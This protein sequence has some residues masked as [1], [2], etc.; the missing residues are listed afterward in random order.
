MFVSF[1]T[2]SLFF[3]A[4]KIPVW[5]FE[6]M[7]VFLFLFYPDLHVLSSLMSFVHDAN[8]KLSLIICRKGK[9]VKMLSSAL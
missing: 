6:L 4:Q 8:A 9:P 3:Y 7:V 2:K 1:L 5:P